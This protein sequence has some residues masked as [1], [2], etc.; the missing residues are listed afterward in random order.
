MYRMTQH[1]ANVCATGLPLKAQFFRFLRRQRPSLVPRLTI[2]RS[3]CWTS[4]TPR[5]APWRYSPIRSNG[6]LA[7][8][9]PYIEL[10]ALVQE[11]FNVEALQQ[12]S[13]LVRFLLFTEHI[14]NAAYSDLLTIFKAESV[15]ESSAMFIRFCIFQWMLWIWFSHSHRS[16]GSPTSYLL[17]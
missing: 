17:I 10:E 8:Y 2:T 13:R 3:L 11:V 14:Q 9:V 15:L 12:R 16:H 5:F 6:F 1:V 7:T 4:D